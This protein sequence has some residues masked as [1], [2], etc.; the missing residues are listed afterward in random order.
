MLNPSLFDDAG[1]LHDPEQWTEDL[2]LEMA[3]ADGFERLDP[4]QM[5]ILHSLRA[6]WSRH[7]GLPTLHH[8][9][10]RHGLAVAELE[11]LFLDSEREAW[12]L[13]GLPHPGSEALAY[14]H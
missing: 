3:Q 12:R 8:I 6:D 2:A 10:H 1:F 13:A 14:M 4:T 7:H 5:A 11:R 9:A